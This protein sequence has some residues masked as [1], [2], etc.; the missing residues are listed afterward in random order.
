MASKMKQI[1]FVL[2]VVLGSL[3]VAAV[4]AEIL[5]GVQ[6][7]RARK[8]SRDYVDTKRDQ[9]LRWGGFLKENLA[10]RVTDGLGGQIR[11]T[12]NAE[13]FRSDRDFSRVPPPGVLRILSLGDSFTAGYRV[14]QDETFSALQDEWVNRKLGKAEILVAETEEP[15]TAL[16]YLDRFGLQLKPRIVLLGITLGNDIAQ[17][18]QAL[19]PSGKYILTIS[20]DRVRIKE[21]HRPLISFH[22][23]AEYKIPADYL[24]PET[25]VERFIRH[26]GLWLR[27]RRLLQRFYQDREAI[28]SWGNRDCPGLFD[29]NNGF[30]MFTKPPPP[31]IDAAYQRL[32]RVLEA[33]SLVCRQQG[34]IFAVQLFPQRYQVQ[35]EDWSRAVAEYRLNQN[36]FDLMAPNR[37]IAAFCRARS[38]A[39]FDPTLCMARRHAD[40]GLNYYL[41]RGD[42]HWNRDG[43]RAFFAC[44]L[45]A[46]GELAQEGWRRV[47]AAGPKAAP[48]AAGRQPGSLTS[49]LPAP[50]R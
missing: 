45:P 20:D 32:F 10:I 3:M 38:I 47:Q 9:G 46:F 24:R 30:G 2:L 8:F 28:T 44:S 22:Q 21:N 31:E 27:K 34:I 13:G 49:G 36:R 25:P 33:F 42:M 14:D 35:P 39:C 16:Y 37:R 6:Q 18:Y 40:T 41:P 5:A 12:N 43:H 1:R 26:A 17:A 11:W 4:L 50:A 23:L 7:N 15:A 29:P 48:G 19:D